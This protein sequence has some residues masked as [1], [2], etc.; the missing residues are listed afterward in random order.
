LKRD[1]FISHSSD[2]KLAIAKP[3]ADAL[4]ASG[5]SV[6]YDEYEI[7]L[8]DSLLQKINEGL[9]HSR[10][11]V[12]ILSKS[13]FSKKWPQRELDGL[14]SLETAAGKSRIIPIWHGLAFEE[15]AKYSPILAGLMAADTSK[16][17]LDRIV[18]KIAEVL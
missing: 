15:V 14:T 18:L 4:I 3:L 6:W 10:F 5:H 17:N 2:D 8:G 13:F 1:V 11:G 7:K 12:V 9:A 16:D